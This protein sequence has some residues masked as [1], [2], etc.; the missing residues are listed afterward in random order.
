MNTFINIS[1][2]IF[3]VGGLILF[4]MGQFMKSRYKIFFSIT[5]LLFVGIFV[6][7]LLVIQNESEITTVYTDRGNLD[8]HFSQVSVY[9]LTIGINILG[10]I[11][12][13]FAILKVTFEKSIPKQKQLT[14]LLSGGLI[15]IISL[16]IY[17]LLGNLIGA[18]CFPIMTIAYFLA[19]NNYYKKLKLD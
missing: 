19:F 13:L 2:V 5:G 16:I 8:F 3:A 15:I 9:F 1:P 10:L 4:I 11:L 6:Y 7:K 14:I 17:K 18:I 12:W